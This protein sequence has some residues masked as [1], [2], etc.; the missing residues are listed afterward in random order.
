[1]N[2]DTISRFIY[3]ARKNKQ[4]VEL[5]I[6]TGAVFIIE[7]WMNY[8]FEKNDIVTHDFALDLNSICSVKC[9]LS[10]Q[11]SHNLLATAGD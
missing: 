8:D 11:G 9:I 1:M 4:A 7:P 6:I 2:D 10:H 5:Q 3:K